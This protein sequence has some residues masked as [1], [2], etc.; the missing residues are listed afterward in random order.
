MQLFHLLSQRETN[1]VIPSIYLTPPRQGKVFNPHMNATNYIYPCIASYT[2]H[3]CT[4][5]RGGGDQSCCEVF[6]IW[7]QTCSSVMPCNLQVLSV[8]QVVGTFQQPAA[9]W[10]Q[11]RP[12]QGRDGGGSQPHGDLSSQSSAPITSH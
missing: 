11:G 1:S 5:P 3:Y 4:Q 7:S 9:D 6:N 10:S 12:P 2:E 8:H